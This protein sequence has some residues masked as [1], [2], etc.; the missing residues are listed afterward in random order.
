MALEDG[1][2]FGASPVKSCTIPNGETTITEIDMGKN[3]AFFVIY[4]LDA[5]DVAASSD[6]SVAAAIFSGT[7]VADVYEANDPGTVWSGGNLPTS[8]TFQFRLDHAWGARYLKFTLSQATDGDVTLYVVGFDP[9]V[10]G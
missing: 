8:G 9:I 4:C 1:I 5:S 10:F 7:A 6:L 2:G 3:Y